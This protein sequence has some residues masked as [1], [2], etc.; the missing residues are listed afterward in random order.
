LGSE[1]E[2][3]KFLIRGLNQIKINNINDKIWIYD[4]ADDGLRIN[5]KEHN[6]G[7]LHAWEYKVPYAAKYA[8]LAVSNM[9]KMIY[10]ATE[11]KNIYTQ[12]YNFVAEYKTPERNVYMLWTTKDKDS[13]NYNLGSNVWYYDLLGNKLDESQVMKDGKYVLTSEPFYAVTVIKNEK[14]IKNESSVEFFIMDGIADLSSL[15]I[16]EIPNGTYNAML[17]FKNVKEQLEYTLICAEYSGN[18]LISLQSFDDICQ[19]SYLQYKRYNVVLNHKD[20]GVDKVKFMIWDNKKEIVPL[21]E[22]FVK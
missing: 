12:D 21:C 1:Y 3:A 14:P 10:G 18:E 22:A 19:A 2:Q 7:I 5:E 15:S 6:F 4:I 8:F 9:N 16:D 20:M 17:A 13:L 11:A